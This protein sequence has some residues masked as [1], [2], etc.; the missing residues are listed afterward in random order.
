MGPIPNGGDVVH[1]GMVSHGARRRDSRGAA[2]SL[3]VTDLGLVHA[4]G[5]GAEVEKT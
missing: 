5:L 3:H 2:P 1:V 4:Q